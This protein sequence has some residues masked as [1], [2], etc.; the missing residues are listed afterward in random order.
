MNASIKADKVKAQREWSPLDAIGLL[1]VA[2]IVAL[3]WGASTISAIYPDPAEKPELIPVPTLMLANL[4]LWAGYLL[5][6]ILLARS[7][8]A[9]VLALNR[10]KAKP[11]DVAWGLVAGV[12]LQLGVLNAL[13][14][15]I[16]KIVDGDPSAAA[17]SLYDSIDSPFQAVLFVLSVV[18]VAPFIEEWFYRGV[19]LRGL[20]SAFGPVVAVLVTSVVFTAVHQSLVQAPG[21]FVFSVVVSVMA[22][23]T[24]RLGMSWFAHAAFNGATVVVLAL[25]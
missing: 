5:L 23:K 14:W 6:P 20:N 2:Q 8:A 12:A 13:Y 4:G 18:V 25:G 17:Q 24:G 10:F 15:F 22:I 21:L 11:I 1:L 19:M 16:L 7:R 9:D 3:L